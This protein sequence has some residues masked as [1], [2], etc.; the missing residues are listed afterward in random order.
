MLQLLKE[1]FSEIWDP[2]L[3]VTLGKQSPY[4]EVAFPTRPQAGELGLG[5][6][7]ASAL[8]TP[9]ILTLSHGPTNMRF[10]RGIS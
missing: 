4:S 9:L 10:A 6:S 5:L 1:F 8:L 7:R 2:V 3:S